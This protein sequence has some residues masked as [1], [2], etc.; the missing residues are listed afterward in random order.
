[1]LLHLATHLLKCSTTVAY[2]DDIS[3]L[4]SRKTPHLKIDATRTQVFV[5]M[6]HPKSCAHQEKHK[7]SLKKRKRN[8]EA[9]LP[10]HPGPFCTLVGSCFKDVIDVQ[11][12]DKTNFLFNAD[13]GQTLAFGVVIESILLTW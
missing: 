5:N 10:F 12:A 3:N 2:R 4:C 7:E 8:T 6:F 11:N 9:A 13:N 1:M